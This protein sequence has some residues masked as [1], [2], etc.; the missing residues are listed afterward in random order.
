MKKAFRSVL[1]AVLCL[2]LLFLPALCAGAAP[3]R[4]ALKILV[5]SDIHYRPPDSMGP[6]PRAGSRNENPILSQFPH[7]HTT[8]KMHYETD[9][10]LEAFFRE[11]EG[12]GAQAL[13]IPGDMSD[14]GHWEEHRGIVKKL[15]E[16]ELRSGI[17]V[18]VT[19][20]N[21]DLRTRIGTADRPG[22]ADFLEMYAQL[23][24]D[25]A[26]ARR[27]GDASYTAELGQGYRLLVADAMLY[28][29]DACKI[30]PELF[31]WIQA[32][33]DQAKKDGKKVIFMTHE[34]VLEH[35]MI[36]GFTSGVLCIDQHRR[37]AT[38]LA[39]AG[40]KYAFTGH[41]HANDISHAVTQ[42]GNKI[43]DIETGSLITHPCAWREVTFSDR[44]VK[45]KTHFIQSID[46][47]LLPE[48][49]SQAQI[50]R[51]REDFL[52]YSFDFMR[53]GFQK[54]SDEVTWQT[55]K[56][57]DALNIPKG[58][59][60][61]ETI[62][63]L[64]RGLQ[65]AVRLPLYGEKDSVE[66]IA[67]R[68]GVKL[69]PSKYYGLLDLAGAV[70][71]GHF[72]GDEDS[73]IDSLEMRLVGQA[74][75]AVLLDTL[76]E[77]PLQAASALLEYAGLPGLPA[78]SHEL[79]LTPGAKLLYRKTA[80]KYFTWE[81]VRTLGEGIFDDWSSPGDRNVTLE[82][83]GARWKLGGRAVEI[84]ELSFWADRLRRL[85][86][87]GVNALRKLADV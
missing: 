57:A 4:G 51:M 9:A 70:Y 25:K 49:F 53:A 17:P 33:L 32:Q 22:L 73:P 30:T 5:V 75:N 13:L 20:G 37:L 68:G 64:L 67:R 54:Y 34:N 82:P 69:E 40:V 86:M 43:F 79:W 87:V 42:A 14:D 36:E 58:S 18:F 31:D 61:Y 59:V 56:L 84:A 74:V 41:Q 10:I 38:M 85:G 66:E 77:M 52:S 62:D 78:P 72:A 65:K 7:G 46:P 35:F 8:G 15:R 50:K 23:G 71:A 2:A 1:G 48:G 21:H 83:Y 28:G 80:A 24:F 19:M 26:L 12:S 60:T 55:D 11:A 81:F 6:L 3:A 16:F 44:D 39:D 27:E 63:A 29:P 76:L 45:I 47:S